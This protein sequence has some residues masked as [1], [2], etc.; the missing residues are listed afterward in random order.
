MS[1]K[2]YRIGETNI[3]TQ[4]LKM[5]IVEYNSA[6]DMIVMFKNLKMGM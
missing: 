2:Q 1:K 5:T 4:G 3:N 6:T